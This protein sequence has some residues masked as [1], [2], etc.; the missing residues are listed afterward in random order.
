MRLM[1]V[2]SLPDKTMK[3]FLHGLLVTS[4]LKFLRFRLIGSQL[5]PLYMWDLAKT[6]QCVDMSHLN[7][8]MKFDRSSRKG[9]V[10]P[11]AAPSLVSRSTRSLPF[12]FFFQI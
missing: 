5:R 2:I 8:P 9:L 10:G 4:G 7:W 12:F 3:K 1:V 11:I 6:R